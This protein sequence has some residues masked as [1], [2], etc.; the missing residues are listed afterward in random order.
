MPK[1]N[2]LGKSMELSHTMANEVFELLNGRH[3]YRETSLTSDSAVK[4]TSW[5]RLINYMLCSSKVLFRSVPF[6]SDVGRKKKE[7]IE[8]K[9]YGGDST[10]L[11]GIENVMQC[12]IATRCREMTSVC[13]ARR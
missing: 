5:S 9:L 7:K 13:S 1:E 4:G 2:I 11:R 12:L 8:I 6:M 10:K 3:G